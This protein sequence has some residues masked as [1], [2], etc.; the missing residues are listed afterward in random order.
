MTR[1]NV[2][3]EDLLDA[4]VLEEPTPSYAALTRWSERY[5]EHREA[6]GEFFATWAVQAELPQETAVDEERL[7]NLAV[8][9]A[10]DLVHR[11]GEAARRTLKAS[12]ARPRL[13]AAARAVGIS[14]EQLAARTGL[15]ATIIEKLDLR[16]ITGVP[17]MCFERLAT[18]LC[19]VADRI[20]EMATGPPLFAAGVRYKAKK[21]PVPATEDFIDAVR[22]SALPDEVKRFWLEAVAAERESRKE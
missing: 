8:S 10:L 6:L 19:T 22:N 11:Q 13:I 21:K 12:N 2:F 15:E 9:H 18:V 17:S 5:P 20:Q 14:E 7:A 1:A 4:I 16:R 3:L